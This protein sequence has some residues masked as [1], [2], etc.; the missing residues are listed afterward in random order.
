M[1]KQELEAERDRLAEDYSGFESKKPWKWR[2]LIARYRK[3]VGFVAGFDAAIKLMEE[4][5][6][7]PLRGR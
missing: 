4:R 5:R 6:V 1:T 7:T 3:H 2:N